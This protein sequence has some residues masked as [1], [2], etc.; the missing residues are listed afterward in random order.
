MIAMRT[1]IVTLLRSYKF[2]ADLKTEE[3]TFKAD[4]TLKLC[5][6]VL[7]KVQKR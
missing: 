3:L 1:M 6:D 4:I 2:E 7:M 5:Q